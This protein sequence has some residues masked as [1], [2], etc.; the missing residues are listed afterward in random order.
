MGLLD[1]K[2]TNRILPGS[3]RG[4]L[5]PLG[6]RWRRSFLM[7]P[8]EPAS[9]PHASSAAAPQV[10]EGVHDIMQ[11]K[12][13]SPPVHGMLTFTSNRTLICF[14]CSVDSIAAF[15]ASG[16]TEPGEAVTSLGSTMAIKMI[17][18]TRVDDAAYGIYSH[19]LGDSWLVGAHA[20]C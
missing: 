16:L 14:G 20:S 12:A 6:S 15:F 4:G 17:S 18:T 2:H 10:R 1:A 8:R 5:S 3:S 13:A 19:R 7:S 11:R 9:R